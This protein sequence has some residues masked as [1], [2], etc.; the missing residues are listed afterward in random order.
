MVLTPECP[1]VEDG[2]PRYLSV[3]RGKSGDCMSLLGCCGHRSGVSREFQRS[4]A[5]RDTACL[6]IAKLIFPDTIRMQS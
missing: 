4:N 2:V 6:N 5:S 1:T 3:D